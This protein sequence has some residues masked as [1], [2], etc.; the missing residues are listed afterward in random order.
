MK[1]F[2]EDYNA[3]VGRHN[4]LVDEYEQI[5]S[6]LNMAVDRYNTLDVQNPYIV[7]IGGGI[8]LEPSKFAIRQ[9]ASSPNL[10]EFKSRISKVGFRWTDT[11]GSKK[12]IRSGSTARGAFP[13]RPRAK[14]NDRIA[15][16]DQIKHWTR[17]DARDGSWKAAVRLDA[18]RAQEKSYDA[19]Q[20]TLQVAEFTAGKSQSLIIAQRDAKGRIVFR[21]A[22]RRDVLPPQDPPR[23]VLT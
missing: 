12:W 10:I 23:V 16:A 14:L 4:E 6:R 22:E 21:R 11:G 1:T 3:L 20:Q 18:S 7:E 15:V 19:Q 9:N 2:S 8:N 17:T 13:V 5:R